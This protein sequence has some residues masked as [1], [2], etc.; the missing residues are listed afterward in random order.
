MSNE[1]SPQPPPPPPP[2]P[3]PAAPP[4]LSQVQRAPALSHPTSSTPLSSSTHLRQRRAQM[5]FCQTQEEWER[6]RPAVGLRSTLTDRPT[7]S[8]PPSSP[9]ANLP[10][11]PSHPQPDQS[12]RPGRASRTMASRRTLSPP[13]SSALAVSR[14]SPRPSNE[15]GPSAFRRSS[16]IRRRRGRARLLPW[17]PSKKSTERSLWTPTPRRRTTRGLGGLR[18][19]PVQ[20][21]PR[22]S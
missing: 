6:A 17:G 9:T 21:L 1:P 13:S 22:R 11:F 20:V 8:S 15:G 3:P 10:L 19:R 7:L 16:R 2:P 14:W 18:G 4:L 12:S 5:S